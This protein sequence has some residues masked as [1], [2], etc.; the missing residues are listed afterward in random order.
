MNIH[1][2]EWDKLRHLAI[3]RDVLAVASARPDVGLAVI[4]T[5]GSV[6]VVAPPGIVGRQMGLR[7]WIDDPDG[8]V[9]IVQARS[10]AILPLLDLAYFDLLIWDGDENDEL[11]EVLTL[12][13][14]ARPDAWLALR[15]SHTWLDPHCK[16]IE[17]FAQKTG[18]HV[19]LVEQ[20]VV[21]PPVKPEA[22]VALEAA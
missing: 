13:R 5:A 18:R 16:L 21:M 2:L 8:K 9:G 11:A 22:V 4:Q 10:E 1:D 15:L 14:R 7:L 20:L 3:R 17:T 19:Q 12:W 6:L